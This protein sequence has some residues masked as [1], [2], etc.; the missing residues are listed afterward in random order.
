M[1]KK[2]LKPVIS[3]KIYGIWSKMDEKIMY[4]SLNKADLELEYGLEKYK[5]DTHL[6]VCLDATYDI[7][8]LER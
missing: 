7:S 5:E 8:S 3:L 2:K 6:V 4:V 1:K